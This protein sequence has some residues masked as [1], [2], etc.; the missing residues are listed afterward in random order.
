MVATKK[1]DRQRKKIFRN[2]IDQSKQEEIEDGKA[3]NL[4]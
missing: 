2:F 1:A 3:S 4:F